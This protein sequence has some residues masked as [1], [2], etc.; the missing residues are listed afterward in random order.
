[1]KF[2]KR[3]FIALT[4]LLSSLSYAK[5]SRVVEIIFWHSLAG[6][7]GGHLNHLVKQFNQQHPQYQ[8]IPIYKGDYV[9]SLTSY[10][11]AYRAHQAPSLVQIY[12]VGTAMMLHPKGI[13]KP[14]H[15]IL[16]EQHIDIPMH[17]FLPAVRETYSQN[18]HLMAMPINVS[19]PILYYNQ[20][21]LNQENIFAFNFPNTWDELG[22]LLNQLIKQGAPCG[23]TSAYPA[24]ILLES[25]AAIQG[26]LPYS[27]HNTVSFMSF[28][29]QLNRL[30]T[31]QSLHYFNYG[32]RTDEAMSLFSSGHCAILSQSSGSYRSLAKIV[33]F[34]IGIAKMPFDPHLSPVRHA[35]LVGGGAIWAT[36]HQDQAHY[37]GIAL[38]IAY[39]A[40]PKTQLEWHQRTGYLPI[41]VSGQ[42]ASILES[43]DQDILTL[44]K[45]DLQN[46]SSVTLERIPQN[47]IRN[48]YDDLLSSLFSGQQNSLEIV[49]DAQKRAKRILKRFNQNTKSI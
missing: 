16:E 12:E 3:F 38:F 33:P 27:K 5:D 17:D 29:T 8:I 47:Q 36:A 22:H 11:A 25:Y 31:W 49:Y 34:K 13:V 35:N 4:L 32:G 45:E 37:R 2:M 14:V 30:K 9:E 7:L 18:H 43:G 24:W 20:D 46:A 6:D 23:Y 21:K 15:E 40:K 41:G 19:I 48:I 26:I 10:A 44:A 39:L 42:Y 1:M 28:I